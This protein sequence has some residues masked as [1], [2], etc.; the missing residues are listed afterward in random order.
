MKW[1]LNSVFNHF[2]WKN[3]LNVSFVLNL[4][5]LQLHV[6]HLESTSFPPCESRWFCG[7][8]AKWFACMWP[9]FAHFMV[10][11]S[12]LFL[13]SLLPMIDNWTYRIFA[14]GIHLEKI[15]RCDCIPNSKFTRWCN[16]RSDHVKKCNKFRIS[17]TVTKVDAEKNFSWSLNKDGSIKELEQKMTVGKDDKQKVE[18][19][20]DSKKNQTKI[21]SEHP[22]LKE[23]LTGMILL[24]M[25]TSNG[26]LIISH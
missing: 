18:A 8:I 4:N 20:Y 1:I 2:F 24:K 11:A 6:L 17:G 14:F 25:S 26:N 16:I 10:I 9:H 21:E 22:K 13:T 23:T 15:F 19:K 12:T 7:V 5:S 3:P